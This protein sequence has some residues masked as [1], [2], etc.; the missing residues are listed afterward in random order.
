MFLPPLLE[1]ATAT[2]DH[3]DPFAEEERTA[4]GFEVAESLGVFCDISKSCVEDPSTCDDPPPFSHA[5]AN[6]VIDGLR[7]SEV[8]GAG[9]APPYVHE[10]V[11]I[12]AS[13]SYFEPVGLAN[14]DGEFID[15]DELP[16]SA[17]GRAVRGSWP[18][19]AFERAPRLGVAAFC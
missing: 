9:F 17:D 4:L 1:I 2:P 6:A 5:A 16:V 14:E 18:A 12:R 8:D 19:D 13:N 10:S 11:R 7:A 3:G 15:H